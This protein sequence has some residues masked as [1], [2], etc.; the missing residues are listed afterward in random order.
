MSYATPYAGLPQRTRVKK[1]ISEVFDIPIGDN[2]LVEVYTDR[3]PY[4]PAIDHTYVFEVKDVKKAL[5]WLSGKFKKN[6]MLT[7][8]TGCGKSSFIEQI[9][10]RL[11]IEVF[12]IG[13]HGKMEFPEM[14]GCNQLVNAGSQAAA[15]DEGLLKKAASVLKVAFRGLD[16]GETVLQFFRRVMNNGVVTKYAYGP[17]VSAAS[18][19]DG[20]ILLVD[21]VNF[22]H[23]STIGG[24]NRAL[25][26]GT[27]LIPETGEIVMPKAGFRIA[28]TGNS[29]DGG[30]DMANYKGVQ[31]MNV[32]FM[33]RFLMMKRDY[34]SFQNECRHL[35]KVVKRVPGPLLSA[36]VQTAMEAR[37][38]YKEGVIGTVI[39]TRILQTWAMLVEADQTRIATNPV[40]LLTDTLEF[41][42]L[43]GADEVDAAA[44]KLNLEKGV[45]DNSVAPAM[46]STA[47]ATTDPSGPSTVNLF[48]APNNG[49]PKLWG[50]FQRTAA[51]DE[52]LFHG[53][54]NGTLSIEAKAPGF[55]NSNRASM[56]NPSIPD[57]AFKEVNVFNSND[58]MADLRSLQE[59]YKLIVVS[60]KASLSQSLAIVMKDILTH[61]GRSDLLSNVLT[62]P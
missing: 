54:L 43:D 5:Q 32:A 38:A 13:A 56:I 30:D 22:L 35:N 8:P 58:V 59:A 36:M 49:V 15:E 27:I 14:L 51:N 42:L 45:K 28:V 3:T 26:D 9:A 55:L 19:F 2:F 7:G 60:S 61:I 40:E 10:A 39:S 48:V 18:R 47:G 6:L 20:G 23:P 50:V 29:L 25:D 16:D 52:N 24:F 4:V 53:P 12:S 57:P 46:P 41:A 21:E 44:I 37:E 17:M 34:M 33:N 62:A 31:R 11:N 1:K